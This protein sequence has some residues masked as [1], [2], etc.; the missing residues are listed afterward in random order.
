[1][2]HSNIALRYWENK[3]LKWERLRYSKWFVLYPL[4][5]TIRKRLLSSAKIINSRIQSHWSVLELGCGSGYLARRIANRIKNYTGVDIAHNAIELAKKK[6]QTSNVHFIATDVS[7]YV[8]DRADL[9]I[10]LGLT[11]W[12]SPEELKKLLS[13]LQSEHIFFSYTE[14][15]A[16]SIWSPYRY[17]RQFIDKNE[18]GKT[19]YKARTYTEDE[20]KT[21]L[22][23]SGYSFEPIKTASLFDP[24]ALIWAKK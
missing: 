18:A 21:L 14:S 8:Y 9:T 24:G 19:Q 7:R 16:V 1:M 12:L 3:I 11:D 10:F 23:E 13:Q 17:Y 2:N 22:K 4:S 15:R 6:N 5:W 20:I